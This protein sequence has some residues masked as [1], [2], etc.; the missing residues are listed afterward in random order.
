MREAR[1]DDAEAV[2]RIFNPLIESGRYTVFQ[3]PFTVEEERRYIETFPARGVFHVAVTPG[4]ERVVGFQSME[5]FA[6]YTTAFDHV[7]V[8]GTYVDSAYQRRGVAR[9]LFAALFEAARLKGYEKLFTYIRQDNPAA[10]ATYRSQGFRIVGTSERQAK[11]RGRY[12][13]EIIVEKL[14]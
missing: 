2:V 12:V 4:D 8:P 7:G 11:I 6:T 1:P 9:A 10:L 3:R 14:L 5:P 13:D